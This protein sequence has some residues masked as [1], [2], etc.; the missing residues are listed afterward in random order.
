MPTSFLILV[1]TYVRSLVTRSVAHEKWRMIRV[2]KRCSRHMSER[3]R[4]FGYID[5]R[6]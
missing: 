6:A 4:N 1:I 3:Q 2:A 5:F